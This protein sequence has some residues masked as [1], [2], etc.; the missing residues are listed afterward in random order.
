LLHWGDTQEMVTDSDEG[1]LK[2]MTKTG[3][4][5]YLSRESKR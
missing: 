2:G 4:E 1:R 3:S 5:A